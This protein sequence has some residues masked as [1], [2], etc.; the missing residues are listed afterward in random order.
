DEECRIDIWNECNIRTATTNGIMYATFTPLKG[1]SLMVVNFCKKADF[2]MCAKP[3]VASDYNDVE[4]PES[5][6]LIGNHT[7]KAV[8]QCVWNDA[9]W[10]TEEVKARLLEDT[11]E[12]LREARSKG[13]PSMEGGSVFTTPLESVLCEPFIIPDNWPRMYGM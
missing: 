11:P 3:L 6:A 13:I 8:I 5:E 1:Y 2:L 12:H 10:L 4:M 9:P 7:R